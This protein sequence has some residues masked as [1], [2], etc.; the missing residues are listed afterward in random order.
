MITICSPSL[1]QESLPKS[2]TYPG[3]MMPICFMT[4]NTQ[5]DWIQAWST[6]PQ[7]LSHVGLRLFPLPR[8]QNAQ[9]GLPVR[10]DFTE[11]IR[12]LEK[13]GRSSINTTDPSRTFNHSWMSRRY[14]HN[15]RSSTGSQQIAEQDD[16]I[17]STTPWR[18][19][20]NFTFPNSAPGSPP[21]TERV[22]EWQVL[23]KTPSFHAPNRDIKQP[24]NSQLTKNPIRAGAQ[25]EAARGDSGHFVE[26]LFI[27]EHLIL[28]LSWTMS[29]RSMAPSKSPL[30]P[31]RSKLTETVP[32]LTKSHS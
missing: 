17:H 14:G 22:M 27:K 21:P 7:D 12:L 9:V 13:P 25:M 11:S 6:L 2:A 8:S 18:K 1:N 10:Q 31:T 28:S 29:S 3:P 4:N 30:W 16:E 15:S 19:L 23:S 24:R 20:D 5:N 32:E 26:H